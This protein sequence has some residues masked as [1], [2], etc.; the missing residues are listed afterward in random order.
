VAQKKAGEFETGVASRTQDRGL[1]S[2]RHQASI[3]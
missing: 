1:D 3:S 2:G